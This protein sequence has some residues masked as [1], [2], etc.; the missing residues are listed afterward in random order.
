MGEFNHSTMAIKWSHKND[1]NFPSSWL[2]PSGCQPPPGYGGDASRSISARVTAD[3]SNKTRSLLSICFSSHGSGAVANPFDLFKILTVRRNE[4]G[5]LPC[6]DKARQILRGDP[7]REDIKSSWADDQRGDD[8]PLRPPLHCFGPGTLTLTFPTIGLG[9]T[10]V[11]H[12]RS[13][14]SRS[15]GPLVAHR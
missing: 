9:T 2:V 1:L 15:L 4:V 6:A 13:R 5:S 12:V 7:S 3:Q 14:D 10:H 11:Q 8:F